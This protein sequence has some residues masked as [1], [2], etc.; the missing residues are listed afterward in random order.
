M[1]GFVTIGNLAAELGIE[2]S[3]LRKYVI[4]NG[5]KPIPV[6]PFE[7][8]GQAVHALTEEDADAIRDLRHRE[9]YNGS[10]PTHS[11]NGDGYFYIV[12][13]VPDVDPCR[14]KVGFAADVNS[15]LSAHRCV[16]P[17][18]CV[19]KSWPC[20]RSWETAAIASATRT[21]CRWIAN[22]VFHAEVVEQIV[23]QA[24]DFF[25]VMP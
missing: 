5:F 23:K 21:G 19:L 15:R 13:V 20:K 22:E 7:S 17:T 9:G 24:D 3:N 11:S 4:K 14:I 25:A 12:Q 6:R 18:A 8:R 16:S 2:K 10:I 1:P